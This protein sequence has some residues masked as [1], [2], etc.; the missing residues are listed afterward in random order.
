MPSARRTLVLP[1]ATAALLAAAVP[2]AAQHPSPAPGVTA[3]GTGV[4]KVTPGDRDS[5][6][7]IKAAVRE[8]LEKAGPRALADARAR[9]QELAT[10]AGVRLGALTAVADPQP[11][12]GGY[13]PFFRSAVDGTFGPG[14]YCGRVGTFRRVKQADG[15]TRRVRTGTRR[16]CRVPSEIASTIVVTYAIA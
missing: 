4:V 15:S 11:G 6:D 7:S 8:A 1:A 9:A 2:A 14:R 16:T 13:P 10:Q 5:N 3:V 12:L